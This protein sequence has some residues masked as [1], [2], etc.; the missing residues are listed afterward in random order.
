M[1]PLGRFLCP[2]LTIAEGAVGTSQRRI[3]TFTVLIPQLVM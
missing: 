3:R 1:Q 2:T